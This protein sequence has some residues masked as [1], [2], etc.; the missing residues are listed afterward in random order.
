MAQIFKRGKKWCYRIWYIDKLGKQHSVSKSFVKKRDAVEQAAIVEAQKQTTNLSKKE[1]ITFYGYFSDWVK[2]YKTGRFTR[3]TKLRYIQTAK[4]IHDF[5][6]NT[7]LKDV[8]RSDYQKFIDDYSQKSK[9]SKLR[10]KK[11]VARIN[12]YIRAAISDAQDEHLVDFDF[13]RKVIVSGSKPKS[14][15][16]KYLELDEP[17]RLKKYAY[18]RLSLRSISFYEILFALSTGCRYGEIVGLT[19][20]DIDFNKHTVT[21]NKTYDYINRSGFKATKTESSIRTISISPKTVELLQKLKQEQTKIFFKQGYRNEDQLVF[22]NN[23]HYIVTNGGANKVLESALKSLEVKANN[24]ITFHGLWHTHASILISKGVGVDYISERLGH[25]DT[26]VT[27][28]VY[29]HLLKDKRDADNQKV[30]NV[31]DNF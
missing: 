19:W 21:I 8:T 27:L 3:N 26:S 31:I 25:A 6:G 16:L 30:L 20:P 29:V 24:I 7:L 22:L 5:F 2:T 11:S 18:E 14:D 12:G 4:M 15:E 23:R 28:R 13:T 9:N 10:S 1:T 17:T